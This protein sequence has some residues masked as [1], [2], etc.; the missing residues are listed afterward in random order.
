MNRKIK[1]IDKYIEE[2]NLAN[3]KMINYDNKELFDFY[4]FE[5]IPEG[6]SLSDSIFKDKDGKIKFGFLK[7][8]K[9]EEMRLITGYTGG[10]KS[11]HYLLPQLLVSLKRGH[12]AIVTDN[13][14]Q[15]MDM[16][17][18]YLLDNKINVRILNFGNTSKSDC[19]NPFYKTV[20]NCKL[21]GK[22]TKE[23]EEL[24]E[25]FA[26]IV[27]TLENSK[28]IIWP[29]GGR[30]ILKGLIYGMIE[31]VIEGAIEVEDVT[32]Y[33]IVQQFYWLNNEIVKSE[34][35]LKLVDVDYYKNRSRF[36]RSLQHIAPYAE[37][38]KVTRAGYLGTLNDNLQ[39]INNSYVFDI[40]SESSFE[41]SELWEKQTVIF[42]NTA[43]KNCAD[44]FTSLFITQLYAEAFEESMKTVSKSLPRTIQL[45]LDEFANIPLCDKEQFTK[46]LT[47]ARK[48][49]IFLNMFIQSY[50]QLTSKF[51]DYVSN[52][53]FANCTQ[54]FIGT[55]DYS[56]RKQFSLSCGMQMIE[57][58]SSFCNITFPELSNVP[59][60]TPEE[61]GKMKKGQMY[62]LRNGY[63]VINTFF[64][65]AYNMELFKDKCKYE[66][67]FPE[68]KFDYEE[69]M[70]LQ[71]AMVHTI[72]LEKWTS[73]LLAEKF[74]NDELDEFANIYK[75]KNSKDIVLLQK[76]CKYGILK[77]L[78]TK[79]YKPLIPKEMVNQAYKKYRRTFD[80]D[81]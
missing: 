19:Y 31:A 57:S 48:M 41:I 78:K 67:L 52:I 75:T 81:F 72:P 53:I 28:D 4:E 16:C 3:S 7:N 40:T 63:D 24:I 2:N 54:V 50:T 30:S 14:G 33:N 62:I 35:L 26:K 76:A 49:R 60:L 6:M 73:T 68:R 18:K 43:D 55:N 32:I 74:T 44:I 21:K 47:T 37:N 17:Y 38:A 42:I 58:F 56:S 1:M 15:L 23:A 64:E 29:L 45:F 69:R 13:S 11:M 70:V 77:K 79:N 27:V 34:I 65:G 61:L 22:I 71:P 12:S 46:M 36:D 10:G 51:D 9:G 8:F 59:V 25:K 20:L 66:N 39:K 5:N 80:F